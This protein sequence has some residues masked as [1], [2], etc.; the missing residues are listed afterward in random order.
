MGETAMERT[1][2]IDDGSVTDPGFVASMAAAR[3]ELPPGDMG[4]YLVD[5]RMKKDNVI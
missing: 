2:G 1:P 3:A 5:T 4:V